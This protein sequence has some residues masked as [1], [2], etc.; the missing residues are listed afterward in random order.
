MRAVVPELTGLEEGHDR[1]FAIG[2]D[3]DLAF[4]GDVGPRVLCVARIGRMLDPD[5]LAFIPN[6]EVEVKMGLR[7]TGM[8]F[9]KSVIFELRRSWKLPVEDGIQQRFMFGHAPPG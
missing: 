5:H 9:E 7:R 8:L 2:A 6:S 3:H 4:D 1:R